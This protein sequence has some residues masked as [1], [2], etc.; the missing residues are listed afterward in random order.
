MSRRLFYDQ[1]LL[2]SYHV[3][4]KFGV[5]QMKNGYPVRI[6]DADES[7]AEKIISEWGNWAREEINLSNGFTIVAKVEETLAGFLSVRW[8]QLPEPVETTEVGMLCDIEVKPE[9]RRQGIATKLVSIAEERGEQRGVYQ[10][11]GWSR[12]DRTEAVQF[13]RASGFTLWPVISLTAILTPQLS[14]S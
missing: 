7:L 5:M 8:G 11:Q 10:L 3:Y 4:Y 12:Q 2:V 6:L 1:D 14:V 9:Y 13:W